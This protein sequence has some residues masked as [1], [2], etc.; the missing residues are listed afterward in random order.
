MVSQM[1]K[2]TPLIAVVD[3]EESVRN[4]LGRLI[5]AAGFGVQTFSSGGDFLRSVRQQRPHC[6]VL[7]IRMAG[8]NGFDVQV[9]LA[10]IRVTGS[11]GGRTGDDSVE[12]R[13]RALQHGAKAYL[14]KPVDD[15]ILLDAIQM[16]MRSAP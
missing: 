9:A 12:Y 6:V 7:D 10:Q 14:R 1:G 11:H 3:D 2:F 13:A 15:S 4:A 5:S 8:M 16:A